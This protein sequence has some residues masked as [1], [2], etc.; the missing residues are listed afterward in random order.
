MKRLETLEQEAK[1]FVKTRKSTRMRLPKEKPLS[2]REH[3][4]GQA[5]TGLLSRSQGILSEEDMRDLIEEAYKIADMM[6]EE[7]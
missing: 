6:L 4:A 2:L 5:L 1:T 3:H 7:Q